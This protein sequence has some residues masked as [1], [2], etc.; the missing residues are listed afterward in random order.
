M[1]ILFV[2]P[3]MQETI[4]NIDKACTKL[5]MLY[6]KEAILFSI[7]ALSMALGLLEKQAIVS[8]INYSSIFINFQ[9]INIVPFALLYYGLCQLESS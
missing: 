1:T 5:D 2:L 9:F 4:L 7:F 6:V 8:F 3:S